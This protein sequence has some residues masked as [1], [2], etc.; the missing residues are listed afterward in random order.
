MAE[1]APAAKK[2]RGK[3]TLR[4]PI[5]AVYLPQMV[6]FTN[7]CLAYFYYFLKVAFFLVAV[8]NLF[9]VKSYLFYVTPVGHVSEFVEG[10]SDP[11]SIWNAQHIDLLKPYC[12]EGSR[13]SFDYFYGGRWRYAILGLTQLSNYLTI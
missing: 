12:A 10:W 11:D 7:P 5:K 4:N 8:L 6:A 9:A 3:W 13:R 1:S 2:Q